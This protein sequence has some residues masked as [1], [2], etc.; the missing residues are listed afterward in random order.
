MPE[1]VADGSVLYM[2]WVGG[3]GCYASPA[4][5][6]GAPLA[7]LLATH[8]NPIRFLRAALVAQAIYHAASILRLDWV[9]K[10]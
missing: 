5:A 1:E 7:I 3:R 2:C 10:F 4:A 8:F 6:G 9:F